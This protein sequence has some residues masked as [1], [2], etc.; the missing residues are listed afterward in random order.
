APNI[1]AL[2]TR[3]CFN[4]IADASELVSLDALATPIEVDS[5]AMTI[6]VGGGARYGDVARELVRHELA[7][8]TMA[9][10]P[11]ITVAGAISTGT[12][13]SGNCCGGLATAVSALEL[14]LSEGDML[15]ISRGDDDFAGATVGLGAL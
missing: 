10:L 11:H 8:R 1:R 12:H 6:T 5:G 9:S 13:G 3:H 7:L 15:H 14:V 4:D 2:G